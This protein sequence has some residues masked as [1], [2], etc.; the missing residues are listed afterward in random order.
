MGVGL[1]LSEEIHYDPSGGIVNG[2]SL[3]Y[4]IPTIVDI[5]A[6][7][8]SLFQ[9]NRDGPGPFGSKGMGEGGI[10]A[11]GPAICSAIFELT[12]VYPRDFPITP[13]KLWTL[14]K[15]S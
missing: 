13:E 10:L 9:E 15:G 5:P 1:A 12:G 11:V 3:D 4:R 2:S 14:L 7:L 6:Q 8:T